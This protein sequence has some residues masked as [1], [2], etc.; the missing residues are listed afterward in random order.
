MPRATSG[1]L[2]GLEQLCQSGSQ[3][4]RPEDP[5]PEG[6][7][8][9]CRGKP[10]GC[11]T[12]R[13]GRKWRPVW[14]RPWWGPPGSNSPEGA[15]CLW[16][17]CGCST[18]VHILGSGTV[19]GPRPLQPSISCES[20]TESCPLAAVGG[21]LGPC[22]CLPRPSALRDLRHA[23]CLGQK[24]VFG[25]KAAAGHGCVPAPGSSSVA[26]GKG[27]AEPGLF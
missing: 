11:R 13:L 19:P 23:L 8:H 24:P 5:A 18:L 17:K 14:R 12:R 15:G 10:V 3:R 1:W 26:L 27:T 2:W 22:P 4:G 6:L 7:A 25:V 21:A 16:S 20:R 9:Q